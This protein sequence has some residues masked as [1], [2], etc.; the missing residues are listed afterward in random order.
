MTES[1]VSEAGLSLWRGGVWKLYISRA[2]TA[3][4]DRLWAF[5]LGLLLYRIYPDNLTLVAAFGLTDSFVSI[6]L[7]AAVG[8]WIDASQ[9]LRAAKTFLVI[10]NLFVAVDCCIFAVFFHW[11]LEI[12]QHFGDWIKVVVA[13]VTIILA[14][15]SHLASNGSKI[16]VEK[17]WIVVISGGNEDKLAK[18]N[19]IFRTIDL[20]CL[21]VAPILAG[22]LFSYTTYAVTA[23]VIAAWNI[24]SVVAEYLLLISIYNQFGNLSKKKANNEE[25]KPQGHLFSK[26]T[27]SYEGWKYYF[28]H[29]VRNAGL[30]L[31]FLYMTVLGFDSTTWAYSLLQCVPESVLGVLIAGSALVGIA[32]SLMFPV[33]RRCL[34]NT[35]R[36]GVMGM[37]CLV[38][39]LSLC[40]VSIWL[41]GS[42]F[43][44][45]HVPDDRDYNVTRNSTDI[46][47]NK[48]HSDATRPD[49]T[50]VSVML[51]G[52]IAARFG[53][54]LS[55][56]SVT[57]IIQ[58]NV[59]ERKRGAIGGVQ[60]SLNSSL[61]LIKFCLV[62]IMPHQ[63]MFGILIILS[64]IFICF[65]A[66][67]LTSYAVKEGKLSCC[68]Q[69]SDY[70][71][72]KTEET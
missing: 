34:G 67:S 25:S 47:D 65:G 56:L 19:A 26:L 64:F 1:T 53:L 22:I 61:N 66:I 14:L 13:I 2:L 45:Y 70:S 5:G 15:V 72:A 36:S 46:I 31:A 23:V 48:C 71:P 43:D 38:S 59:E 44:P 4:G 30:G 49:I 28:C 41:P 32:G 33:A 27:G 18:L 9:R 3:W 37:L 35:E 68:C 10:Q 52:I 69:K 20:V 17:D 62:L 50:S 57:Q 63:E 16:V 11:Q 54:W 40:V 24:V 60:T 12:I 42:P 8:N 39:A 51:A 29:K 21:N 55:D 58:E 7:G 6:T